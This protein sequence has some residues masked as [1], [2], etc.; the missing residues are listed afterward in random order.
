MDVE[1]GLGP[2]G[3]IHRFGSGEDSGELQQELQKIPGWERE[4]V[5]A[6]S[7][8]FAGSF[9]CLLDVFAVC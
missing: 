7:E 4:V 9:G 1:A 5:E 3:V 6:D 8:E 2:A